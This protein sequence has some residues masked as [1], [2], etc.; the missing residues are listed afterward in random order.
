MRVLLVALCLAG[1]GAL[2]ACSV[3]TL[4]TSPQPLD[5]VL[6]N[7]E[8]VDLRSGAVRSRQDVLLAGGR[9]IDIRPAGTTR[10]DAAT[11]SVDAGGKF[12]IP[13]LW[14]MHVH[15]FERETLPLF[16]ANGVVGV[17]QMSATTVH[18]QWRAAGIEGT[19]QA[20]RQVL[21]TPLVDGPQPAWPP[22]LSVEVRDPSS[23]R[24]AV[25]AFAKSDA[26]FVKVYTKL[27]RETYL[28]ILA[29][30]KDAGLPVVGHVPPTVT[31]DE[32]IAAGH[33]DIHHLTEIEFAV[34]A[35]GGELLPQM[36]ALDQ[37]LVAGGFSVDERDFRRARGRVL[38]AALDSYDEDR[39]VDLLA[40]LARHQVWQ[41]P[42]RIVI[43]MIARMDAHPPDGDPRLAYLTA[44]QR[45]EFATSTYH[46]SIVQELMPARLR[47]LA[48][49]RDMVGRMR[50]AGVP[51][52]AGTDV[53]TPYLVPGFSLHDELA[54]LVGDGLSPLDALRTATMN[55]ARFLGREGDFGL[56]EPGQRA[57][58]VVLDENPLLDIRNTQA[59]AAVVIGGQVLD[60]AALDATLARVREHSTRPHVEEALLPTF[61]ADGIDANVRRYSELRRTQAHTY[62][63]SLAGPNLIVGKLV[64]EQRW[65]E[66]L[67]LTEAATQGPLAD[68]PVLYEALGDMYLAAGRRSEAGAA[69]RRALELAPGSPP[70]MLKLGQMQ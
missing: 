68:Q 35:R 27:P 3:A 56:V 38:I 12:V 50:R 5:T 40:S 54:L 29:A 34:S 44:H 13:G 49:Y 48:F 58:L 52:L 66:L 64:R 31:W 7:A 16:V 22:P 14:D 63:F 1:T 8:V 62:N 47:L 20:P 69:W 53:G 6:R 39:A 41:T 19:P 45:R 65:P 32:A 17:R 37:K 59:I 57:D 25:A 2:V 15:W 21:G 11:L 60:R 51:I 55:P 9:I 33:R 30:A 24:Q 42:T 23:G 28:A 43:E 26:E 70:L 18:W 67:R 36:T 46:T 61:D 4:R 10:I